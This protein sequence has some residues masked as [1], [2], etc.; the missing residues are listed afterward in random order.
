MKK[1]E[2]IIPWRWWCLVF[3]VSIAAEAVDFVEMATK[4]VDDD[5]TVGWA[6]GVLGAATSAISK[7]PNFEILKKA[8]KIESRELMDWP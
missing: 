5:V 1:M 7:F 3:A 2:K 6:N 8:K 4:A